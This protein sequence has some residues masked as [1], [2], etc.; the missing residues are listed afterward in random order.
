MMI[1]Q[2]FLIKKFQ[3]QIFNKNK[4]KLLNEKFKIDQVI[5]AILNI[6]DEEKN[7]IL[8]NL[9]QHDISIK[10]L[11]NVNQLVNSNISLSDFKEI[12]VLDLIE[13]R[14]NKGADIL[15]IEFINKKILITGAGGSIGSELCRA[16]YFTI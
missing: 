6:K 9:G 12:S 2:K 16:N 14:N 13:K 3:Y 4:I 11:P 8:V 5:I 15:D 10:I 7:K 1:F